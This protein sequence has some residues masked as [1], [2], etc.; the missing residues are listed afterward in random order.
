MTEIDHTVS[1]DIQH[2]LDTAHDTNAVGA[3]G[4]NHATASQDMTNV[5]PHHQG[6][7]HF[8]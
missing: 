7:F 4:P 1:T 8:A 3:L 2:L 5:Q 6:D